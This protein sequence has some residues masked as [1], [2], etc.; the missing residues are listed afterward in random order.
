MESLSLQKS[1]S[2]L[3]E[4]LF[5]CESSGECVEISKLLG[6]QIK[7]KGY[8]LFNTESILPKLLSAINNKKSGLEREG[9]ALGI[10]GISLVLGLGCLPLLMP[11]LPV[12][13]ELQGDKGVPV[14]EAGYMAVKQILASCDE[15]SLPLVLEYLLKGS[16]GKWQAKLATC[17]FLLELSN[18]FPNAMADRLPEIIPA[19]TNCM[20]D[21][22]L[23][24]SKGAIACMTKLCKVVGNPDINPHVGLLIDCMANP[25]HVIKAVQTLSATTF[26]AEVTGPAL[27]LMVPLLVRALNDRSAAV[28]RPSVVIADNLFKLVRNPPD[29]GQFMPQLLPGLDRIIETAAFPEIRALAQAAR[30]TLVE[31]AGGENSTV[32]AISAEQVAKDLTLFCKKNRTV[33]VAFFKGSV[34]YATNLISNL[35]RKECFK[36]GVWQSGMVDIL[37]PAIT[38]PCA[39]KAVDALNKLYHE[40]YRATQKY[41]DDDGDDEGELLCD[42]EFS[43]AYGGMKHVLIF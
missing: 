17:E 41:G 1:T 11:L 15:W 22:K 14:R 10:V 25:D 28:M 12:L 40:Q 27:A 13:L 23:E 20:H 32:F 7:L 36:L 3:I 30:L 19:V 21:T 33:P 35:I 8:G 43:L 34:D 42:L 9:G 38:L 24:V 37:A 16:N 6:E 4:S 18:R 39:Q 29:A 26:V 2:E 5:S 31:S